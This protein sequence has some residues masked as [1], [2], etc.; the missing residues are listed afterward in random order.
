[1]KTL[2]TKSRSPRA[3]F[4]RTNRHLTNNLKIRTNSTGHNLHSLNSSN[5]DIPV[6]QINSRTNLDSLAQVVRMAFQALQALYQ[7]TVKA[8]PLHL[9]LGTAWA[10]VPH[11]VMVSHL[12]HFRVILTTTSRCQSV[13]QANR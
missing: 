8:S 9:L 13:R 3:Q 2:L 1:M 7:A 11:L 5:L 10:T 6:L 12:S 4:R